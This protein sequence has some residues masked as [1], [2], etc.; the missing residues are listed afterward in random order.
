MDEAESDKLCE[1]CQHYDDDHDE[2][3]RCQIPLC[4]CG[5]PEK[6]KT[7]GQGEWR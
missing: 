3:R 2:Q 7:E 1:S 6:W 5:H 4:P